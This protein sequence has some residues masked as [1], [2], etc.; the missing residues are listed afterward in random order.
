LK[1]GSKSAI[2]AAMKPSLALLTALLHAAGRMAGEVQGQGFLKE[3][4][5]LTASTRTRF[6]AI[7]C[8]AHCA[9]TWLH[10]SL[11]HVWK[12]VL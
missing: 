8:Q 3:G 6:L 11:A 7:Y 2:T 5:S 1:L 4:V 9:H 10:E 12:V